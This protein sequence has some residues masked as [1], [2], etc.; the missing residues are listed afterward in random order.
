[1][2]RNILGFIFLLLFEQT[3]QAIDAN[4]QVF[5]LPMKKDHKFG[6]DICYYREEIDEK[7]NY[8]IYY[9]KPCEK[10]KYCESEVSRQPFGFC[11]DILTNAT[12]FPNYDENCNS[13][14]ECPSGLKCDGKCKLECTTNQFS[15][16][17]GLNSFNCLPTNTKTTDDGIHCFLYEPQ[18]QSSD[19]KSYDETLTVNNGKTIGKYPG[20]PKECG[21]IRYSSITDIFPNREPGETAYKTYTRW[22]EKSRDW[23]S[24]GEAEDGDFVDDWRFCK[25]GFTLK[26]YPKGD[27]VDPSIR[28]SIGNVYT[29]DKVDMCVTPI[30]I[31]KSNPE[32]NGPIVTYKIKDGDEQ[33]YNYNK[34]YSGTPNL[35]EEAVIKSQLYTEFIEEFKNASEEDKKNCYKIPQA[36]PTDLNAGGNCQ[37]IKLLKLF[38]FYSH[39]KEYL[40]Y[41]D[42]K[43]LEKVLHFKI[44]QLHYR[45]YEL[46]KYLNL[47][48]LFLLLL[49][50]ILL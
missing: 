38:Y 23:C 40:F 3:I 7:R 49:Y 15:F 43:D 28:D 5:Y 4:A 20:L 8:V 36:N 22:I 41:K 42:R 26:F 48:C 16:R 1:M 44:Q 14:G 17:D 13:N 33:K 27:L 18:Y 50:L 19:P 10:G 30:R 11:R 31:D 37:N 46:S 39:I 24:I 47:N 25:S 12:D 9:V 6:D 34:Y 2:N 35:D 45:Y 32:V 29:Q 21:I